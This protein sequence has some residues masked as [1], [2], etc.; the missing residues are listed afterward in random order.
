MNNNNFIENI[1]SSDLAN[2]YKDILLFDYE[3]YISEWLNSNELDKLNKKYGI[4]KKI[5]WYKKG[6]IKQ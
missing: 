4:Y 3:R 2:N 6:F 5:L 1:K